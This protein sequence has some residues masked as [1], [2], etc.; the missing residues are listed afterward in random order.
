MP[1]STPG[2]ILTEEAND[3]R[4][5]RWVLRISRYSASA[6]WR[7]CAKRR[8]GASPEAGGRAEE[9][10]RLPGSPV[11]WRSLDKRNSQTYKE[12]ENAIFTQSVAHVRP[13]RRRGRHAAVGRPGGARFL[14][15]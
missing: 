12:I 8:A 15:G 13:F 1:A 14:A 3:E 4:R 9:P 11:S 10:A 2:P 5:G 7:C 6:A